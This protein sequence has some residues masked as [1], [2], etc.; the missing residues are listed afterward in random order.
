MAIR[1]GQ[2]DVLILD[3]SNRTRSM[4]MEPTLGLR[5]KSILDAGIKESN[6]ATVVQFLRAEDKSLEFGSK[7]RSLE[8]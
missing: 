2:M 8:P 4:A 3:I 6:M 5:I 7:E 1:P